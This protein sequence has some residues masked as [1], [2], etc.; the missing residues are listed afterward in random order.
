V[1][2]RKT[3]SDAQVTVHK[4][5][6]RGNDQGAIIVRLKAQQIEDRKRI[7][8]LLALTQ[9]VT[10][11]ITFISP[12]SEEAGPALAAQYQE[13]ISNA[14]DDVAKYNGNSLM[15]A[16]AVA[17]RLQ[18]RNESL[19]MTIDSLRD[20][21]K[22]YKSIARDKISA[23]Y[24]DRSIREQQYT[25]QTGDLTAKITSLTGKLNA[26]EDNLI[27]V[28]KDYL[29]LRHNAQVAQ[30]VMV[31]EK[32]LLRAERE[33][34]E[35]DR[36]AAAQQMSVE[37][38]AAREASAAEIELATNDFR[39][40]VQARERDMAVLREQYESVQT[41]YEARIRDLTQQVAH[42]RNKYTQINRRRKLEIEGNVAAAALHAREVNKLRKNLNRGGGKNIADN[43]ENSFNRANIR[44]IG[45]GT[46]SGTGSIPNSET[47]SE[48]NLDSDS[49]KVKY[50]ENRVRVMESQMRGLSA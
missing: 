30:R 45:S 39:S 10:S 41:V 47:S 11:D 8:R 33:S 23:L 37:M 21:L 1:E 34:L 43:D 3:V 38:K 50:L 25:K 28:T 5:R 40:Q 42:F 35:S 27:A 4:E 22:S 29:V 32:Q 12:G 46:G 17:A 2:L 18:S 6:E 19:Q 13:A 16:Q 49:D 20:Q 48:V 44:K 15:S 24:E 26:T 9:P 36:A 31:E 7:Q 14:E